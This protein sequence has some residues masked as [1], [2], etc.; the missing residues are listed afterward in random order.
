MKTGKRFL[1]VCLVVVMVFAVMLSAG[2]SAKNTSTT[3]Q[4]TAAKTGESAATAATTAKRLDEVKLKWVTAWPS[5]ETDRDLVFDAVN[6]VVKEKINASVT[7]DIID[8]GQWKTRI[9][10]LL[11]SNED[12]DVVWHNWDYSYAANVSKGLYKPMDDLLRDYGQTI[13][14]DIPAAFLDIQRVDGKIYAIPCNQISTKGIVYTIKQECVDKTGF[15]IAQIKGLYDFDPFLKAI[16]EKLP[17]LYPIQNQNGGLWKNLMLEKGWEY[18]ISGNGAPL[19]VNYADNT[20]KVFNVYET[21]EFKEYCDKVYGWY[22]AG[23]IQKD[24]A[25]T[26]SVE[27]E[28]NAG[29]YGVIIGGTVEYPG[30][31]SAKYTSQKGYPCTEVITSKNFWE[32]TAGQATM[33]CIPAQSKNPERAMMLLDLFNDDTELANTLAYGIKD[34]HYI[35]NANKQVER[36]RDVGYNFDWQWSMLNTFKLYTDASLPANHNELVQKTHMEAIPSQ[37]ASYVPNADEYTTELAQCLTA[38]QEMGIGLQT[39]VMD[40]AV[41]LPRFLEALK[42]AG[43]D[44]LVETVQKQIDAQLK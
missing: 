2:C 22:K 41:Y 19:A 42:S 38:W 37:L 15:D 1:S 14:R 6:K 28:E 39:G 24:I 40:P 27:A 4:T 7:F 31:M 17:E 33:L 8:F 30:A 3:E 13:L 18:V 9:P 11:A 25:S 12:M 23:Y 36:K 35:L 26:Q 20:R 21:P 43:V 16:K 10:V 29:K 32:Y 44:K 5:V 34:K